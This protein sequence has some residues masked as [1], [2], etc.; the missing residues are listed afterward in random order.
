MKAFFLDQYKKDAPLRLR[1]TP[2]PETQ[3]HD[4]LVKINA[5]SVNPLDL[6]IR[7]GA[8]KPF[9]PYRPPFVLGHDLAG[10]VVRVGTKVTKFKTGD[11]VYARPSDGRIGTFAEIIAVNEDDTALKPANLSM[12]E[13]ASIPLVG[14][15]SWQVFTEA[16]DLKPGDKILIHAGSGGVGTFAIQLAKQMGATVA[17]TVSATNFELVQSLGA[18]LI[19]DY[20]TQDLETVLSDYDVVLCSQDAK[21]LEKSLGVLRPGGKLISISGPPDLAFARAQKLNWPLQQVMRGL[22]FNI[23]RKAKRKDV[24]YS[25][26]FMRA[27][28]EQLGKI[29]P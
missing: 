12:E 20:K 1:E 8:F 6:K 28:G 24:Q 14:L 26:V 19:I 13:A 7:D 18:D 10:T 11:E 22:S 27:S 3:A 4:L 9:L 21:I 15:T 23:R 5:T 16:S 2:E 17:T 25:F 29:S